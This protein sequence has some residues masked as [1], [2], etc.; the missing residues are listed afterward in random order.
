[1]IRDLVYDILRN[2]AP[3]NA[4]QI[5]TN[6]IYQVGSMD[7]IPAKPALGIQWGDLTPGPS[8]MLGSIVTG[9]G[10]SVMVLRVH[11]ELGDYGRIDAILT[12]ARNALCGSIGIRSITSP[13]WTLIQCDWMSDSPDLRD[14]GYGTL[15]RFSTYRVATGWR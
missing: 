13:G 9:A 1:M 8:E 3:L 5:N 6:S 4:L 2:S 15:T 14:D 7:G 12:A 11:D 10:T